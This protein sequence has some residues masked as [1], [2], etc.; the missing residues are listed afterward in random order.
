MPPPNSPEAMPQSDATPFRLE[1]SGAS[2]GKTPPT[3]RG[4][5]RTGVGGARPAVAPQQSPAAQTGQ[6]PASP[7]P[8][9]QFQTPGAVEATTYQ[10]FSPGAAYVASPQIPAVYQE[11]RP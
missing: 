9:T 8:P 2:Q 1:S 7:P 5:S 3:P 11:Q 10:D 4:A 6:W